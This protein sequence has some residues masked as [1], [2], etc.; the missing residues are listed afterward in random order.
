MKQVGG[1]IIVGIAIAHYCRTLLAAGIMYKD[2]SMSQP[3]TIST[4]V[5]PFQQEGRYVDRPF[6]REN[7]RNTLYVQINNRIRDS[8]CAHKHANVRK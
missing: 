6:Q 7:D 4:F 1:L 3:A 8:I 5:P 2:P